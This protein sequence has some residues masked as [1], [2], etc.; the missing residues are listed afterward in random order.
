MKKVAIHQPHYFPWLGYLDKMAK[1]DEFVVM[2]E[3]QLTDRSPMVRNKFLQANG[4]STLLSVSVDKKGYREKKMSEIL[5]SDWVRIGSKHLTFFEL[6]YKKTPGFDEVMSYVEPILGGDYTR[7]LDLEL[8]SMDA[9]RSVY[10]IQT[11][12]VFQ[13]EIS[14][15][16]MG[17][18]ND[19]ILN[20][21]L[22]SNADVYLSGNGAREYMIDDDFNNKGIR[23]LYQDFEYPYYPQRNQSEFVPNLS[24]LDLAFQCGIDEARDVFYSNMRVEGNDQ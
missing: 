16:D 20:L 19:L 18:N 2:D 23:V 10:D 14:S 8:A 7:L 5:L 21:C 1:V 17:K 24:A 12:L 6:N 3:V 13:S 4:S 9:L 11:P 15:G 22:S